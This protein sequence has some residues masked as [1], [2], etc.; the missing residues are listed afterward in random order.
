[1]TLL[2]DLLLVLHVGFVLFVIAG[3]LAVLRWPRLAWLHVPAVVWGALVELMGW[4]CPLTPLEHRLRAGASPTP[5]R[6]FIER[7]LAGVLYPDWLTRETQ[8]A[9]GL[10]VLVLNLAVYAAVVARMRRAPRRSL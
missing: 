6:D 8:I 7:L 1:M 3:G 4:I 9:L 2:A 5:E 10:A